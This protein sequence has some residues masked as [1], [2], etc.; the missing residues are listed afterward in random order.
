[1]STEDTPESRLELYAKALRNAAIEAKAR[2]SY[3]L[4]EK[5]VEALPEFLE[6]EGC[7]HLMTWLRTGLGSKP[8]NIKVDL[9]KDVRLGITKATV[10]YSRD[11]KDHDELETIH[12]DLNGVPLRPL[13]PGEDELYV[14]IH[15]IVSEA[16]TEVAYENPLMVHRLTHRLL[17]ISRE[18]W[19]GRNPDETWGPSFDAL[20]ADWKGAEIEVDTASMPG[21]TRAVGKL[22]TQGSAITTEYFKDSS[23]QPSERDCDWRDL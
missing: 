21:S 22:A 15:E 17:D 13:Q 8:S 23:C 2:Q 3:D 12:V 10:S 4:T 7:W 1:M 18:Q 20:T 6:H 16:S 14:K 5:Q 19:L 9:Q 11:G